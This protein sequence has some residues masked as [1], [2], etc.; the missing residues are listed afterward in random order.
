M[1]P[2]LP[3]QDSLSTAR[4]TSA[5]VRASRSRGFTIVDLLV[6]IVVVAILLSILAPSMIKSYE[7]AR[8]VVCAAQ[9]KQVGYA[10]DMYIDDNDDELPSSVLLDRSSGS[11]SS[12]AENTIFLRFGSL[13][14]L[15]DKDGD[16]RSVNDTPVPQRWDG[17]GFLFDQGYLSHRGVFY[18]PS[19]HGSHGLDVYEDAWLSSSQT[20]GSNYQ[21]R[22][23]P[24]FTLRSELPLG[25]TLIAD[26]M[27]TQQDYNHVQGNNMLRADL[28]V[29][30]FED[31]GGILYNSL[32]IEGEDQDASQS[33]DAAWKVL[34]MDNGAAGQPQI[35][36]I[37]AGDTN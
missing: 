2:V 13:A 16:D 37:I 24:N 29:A 30:W 14:S 25:L 18:C 19:H 9:M 27:R 7:M 20:I 33:V 31:T 28:S 4:A 1:P 6:S 32:A 3:N 17:L 26:A 34:D 8:R 35:G 5:V 23:D 15:N 10:L 22:V 36:P 21:Y 12:G 11:D